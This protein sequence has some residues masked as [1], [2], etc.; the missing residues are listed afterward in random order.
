MNSTVGPEPASAILSS[1]PAL[2]ATKYLSAAG[3]VAVLWDHIISLDEEIDYIWPKKIDVTKVTYVLYRYGTEGGFF[4]VAYM[5]SGFRPPLTTESCKSFIVVLF[6]LLMAT[7]LLANVYMALYH[8][9][10]WDHRKGAMYAII[11]ALICTY[12][13]AFILGV[14]QTIQEHSRPHAFHPRRASP[15]TGVAGQTTYF[16]PLDTCLIISG[17]AVG[18]GF[19]ACLVAFDAFAITLAVANALDRPYRQSTDVLSSLR[20]DGAAWF[21]CLFLARLMNFIIFVR[22]PPYEDLVIVLCALYLPARPTPP[23]NRFSSNVWSLI[24]IILSRLILRVEKLK[25]DNHRVRIWDPKAEAFELGRFSN[26]G[27]GIS[28][29]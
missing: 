15:L 22:L 6:C 16:A 4:Y 26:N 5:F 21:F 29:S 13:P 3:M 12:L 11:V 2:L 17:S 23:T 14:I 27:G 25:K 28:P 20:R 9:Q 8:Y 18:K 19:W 7:S 24:A 1:V 10:L